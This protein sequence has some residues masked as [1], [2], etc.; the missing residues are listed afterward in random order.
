MLAYFFDLIFL[1]AAV[2]AIP[3]A[4]I[5][6]EIAAAIFLSQPDSVVNA[7]DRVRRPVAVI[8]PAHNESTGIVATIKD[9]TAQLDESD[10]VLV[11]AD[12]CSDDTASVASM[13]GAEVIVRNDAGKVGK[14]HALDF[15]LRHLSLN[16]PE[17]VIV[18]DADC[19]LSNDAINVLAL[20]CGITR[21]P[22]QALDLMR[23][24]SGA[25]IN[26]HVAEFAWRVK[27][28]VRPLGLGALNLPCQLMGTGMAFPWEVIR[29]AELDTSR[30]AEDLILG[31]DLAAAGTP[32]IFC[33][34]AI[35]TSDFPSSEVGAKTQRQRWE[36]GHIGVV[37]TTVPRLLWHAIVK[38]NWPLLALT[39]DSAVPPLTVLGLLV[40]AI[41]ILA[42]VSMLF[43]N[44][45]AVTIV[46]AFSFAGFCIAIV[47][48]WWQFGR[49][50]LPLK[51]VWLVAPFVLSKFPLYRQILMRGT[52][53]KWVRT[54]RTK[55]IKEDSAS[56]S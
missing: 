12:N 33:P 50:L 10:R 14:G 5:F 1:F 18:I 37:L 19:R 3:V 20:N 52:R 30:I 29:S 9:V 51:H 23:A 54:E 56:K 35:V 17:I 55:K 39:L 43:G 16:P 49:D 6:L 24:P 53:I 34:S 45:P 40:V 13:A 27:N 8:I 32:P 26:F 15:G 38:R 22:I 2:L 31:L 4:V 44:S 25:A 36:L 46:S 47:F 21:R 28:L 48:S 11:I 41:F 42:A 7:S